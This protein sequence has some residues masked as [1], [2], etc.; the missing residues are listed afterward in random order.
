MISEESDESI[1]WLEMLLASNLTSAPLVNALLDEGN[2][3]LSITVASI[4][5]VRTRNS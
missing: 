5:T 1:Y 4:K 2:Q 3:I